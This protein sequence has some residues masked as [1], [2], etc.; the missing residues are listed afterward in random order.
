MAKRLL[1]VMAVGI[2][3]LVLA[4]E[5]RAR[6]ASQQNLIDRVAAAPGDIAARLELAT[7]YV[8]QNRLEEA[9]RL[10]NEALALVRAQR[11]A[12][13]GVQ[14]P[15]D[16]PV[17]VGG[18]V[19]APKLIK[20]VSPRFPNVAQAAKIQGRVTIEALVDKEGRVARTTV[21][22]S[23]PLFDE[24]AIE[25]VRQWRYTPTLLGGQPVEV[26]LVVTVRFDRR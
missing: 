24:A 9:E 20:H 11:Q 25:A 1:A 10:L 4:T 5:V 21:L 22:A 13:A 8:G 26:L 2:V 15:S 23:H 6:Q 14:V 16:V 3:C 18:D 7:L 17:R 19:K 12:A